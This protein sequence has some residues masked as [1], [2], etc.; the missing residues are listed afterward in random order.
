M[1]LYTLTPPLLLLF[2]FLAALTEAAIDYGRFEQFKRDDAGGEN[3]MFPCHHSCR[4]H[5]L[6]QGDGVGGQHGPVEEGEEL[7]AQPGGVDHPRVL[8]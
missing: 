2:L 5:L 4:A 6:A 3:N 7:R 1:K 8:W